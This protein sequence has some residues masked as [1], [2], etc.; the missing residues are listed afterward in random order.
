MSKACFLPSEFMFFASIISKK[1]VYRIERLTSFCLYSMTENKGRLWLRRPG[2]G[3][4]DTLRLNFAEHTYITWLMKWVFVLANIFLC[5]LISMVV[6]TCFGN[7]Y[8]VSSNREPVKGIFVIYHIKADLR[9]LLH[10]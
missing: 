1:L 7:F 5:Q 10:I 2:L 4:I 9:T 6:G 8:N 3:G